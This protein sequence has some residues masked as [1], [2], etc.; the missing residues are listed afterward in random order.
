MN[1][2]HLKKLH[3]R[4]ISYFGMNKDR[5]MAQLRHLDMIKNMDAD[6]C[7]WPSESD[8]L[9][10][11]GW[12]LGIFMRD[13]QGPTKTGI[14]FK[15]NDKKQC[16]KVCM[17]INEQLFGH[18]SETVLSITTSNRRN[19]QAKDREEFDKALANIVAALEPESLLKMPGVYESVS[20]EFNNVAMDI[21]QAYSTD[22]ARNNLDIKYTVREVLEITANT[23]EQVLE[24]PDKPH[25]E[26][27]QVW[28]NAEESLK[29]CR[30]YLDRMDHILKQQLQ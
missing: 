24:L 19:R 5:L 28:K 6:I 22:P 1:E 21:V 13:T 8:N 15:D 25:S 26:Q 11:N 20:E 10:C 30:N 12:Q 16:M 27:K 4:M 7:L 23:L 18:D 2:Q 3:D 17:H 29:L 14:C 9:N